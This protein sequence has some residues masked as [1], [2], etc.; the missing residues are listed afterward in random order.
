MDRNVTLDGPVPGIPGAVMRQVASLPDHLP[1]SVQ[2]GQFAHAR[3]GVLLLA[4]PGVARYLIR[5]GISVEIAVEP[6]ADPAAVLLSLNSGV[7][8]G[9]THQRGELP[10]HAATLVPPGG[11]QAI[12]ICG[13]SG[14]GKSTLAA[15]LVRRGWSLIADDMTPVTW[16]GPDVLAWPGKGAIK[17]WRDACE[18]A[19]LDPAGLSRIREELDK[20][21]WEVPVLAEPVPLR[22][23][24]ELGHAGPLALIEVSGSDRMALL[25]ENTFRRSF[26]VALGRAADYVR[27]VGQVA[28]ACRIV[29]LVGARTVPLAGLADR[30]AEL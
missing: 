10:L 30:I 11:T 13:P 7:R 17:L 6:D 18:T 14:A 15:E 23:V 12:A 5:D 3:P 19:G 2:V 21:Y 16:R 28:G 29:R 26:V 1:D 4:I 24:V 27:L 25:S 8:G 9:L 20:F 22:V